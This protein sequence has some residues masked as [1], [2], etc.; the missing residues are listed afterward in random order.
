MLTAA[1]AI[2]GGGFRVGRGGVVVERLKGRRGRGLVDN[3]NGNYCI[4][5]RCAA[6]GWAGLGLG[7]GGMGGM[8]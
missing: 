4:E 2:R 5:G 1:A 8:R 7:C 6:V 3:G